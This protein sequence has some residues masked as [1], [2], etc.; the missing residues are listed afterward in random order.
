MKIKLKELREK[1]RE[2]EKLLKNQHESI[3]KIEEKCK[4]ITMLINEA[5]NKNS[6]SRSIKPS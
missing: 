2:D 5:K 1:Q 3:I 4:R 6:T